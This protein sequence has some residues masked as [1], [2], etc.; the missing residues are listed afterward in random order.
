MLPAPPALGAPFMF[1][2]RVFAQPIC[3]TS[4]LQSPPK[5]HQEDEEAEEH[6]AKGHGPE[7][8]SEPE[9]GQA[10]TAGPYQGG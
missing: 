4:Q 5:W 6:V 2:K 10:E 7:V 3:S 9:G 1:Q 8:H